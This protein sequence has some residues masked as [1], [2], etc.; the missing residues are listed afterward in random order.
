MWSIWLIFV[1][2]V[3]ILSSL[4]WMSIRGLWKLLDGRYWLWGKLGL[5]LVGRTVLSISLIQFSVMGGAVFPLCS[6][7]WGQT[8]LVVMM[9]SFKRTYGNRLRLPGLLQSVPLILWQATVDWHFRQRL[10]DTLSQIWLHLLWESVLL[11]PVSWCMQGFLRALQESVSPVL[12]KFCNQILLA[13]KV[14]FP[15]DS[16]SLC[17]IPR[18]GNWFWAIKSASTSLVK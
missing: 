17:Q 1:I 12:W 4:W 8:V 18:L 11:F 5:A 6:L 3:S 10:L 15:G 9:I 7:A 2:V 14:K 16:Q 13:F